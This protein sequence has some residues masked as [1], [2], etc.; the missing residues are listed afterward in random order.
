M[1][2]SKHEH[3]GLGLSVPRAIILVAYFA[4]VLPTLMLLNVGLVPDVLVLVLLGAAVVAGHPLLFVRDWGVFLLVVVLWQQ[5]GKVAT[6]A[7]YPLHVHELIDAD[8]WLTWP[9]L[10]G[11]LPQVWL[12]Q[13]LYHAGTWQWYDI[14]SWAVYGLHFPEPLL[15]GFVIWLRDPALFRR[16]SI[17]FLTL[18]SLAFAVY[19]LYPAVPPWMAASRHYPYRLIPPLTNI[20]NQFN[21]DVLTVGLGHSYHTVLHVD[22][23]LTAAMPSLHAAFPLLSALYLRKS[24][25]RWGLLMLGYGL[26]VWFSVVYMA[27]H[28]VIDVLAGLACAVIAY[29][30]VEAVARLWR[31]ARRTAP[32]PTFTPREAPGTVAAI[33]GSPN[34]PS[35][36]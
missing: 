25:G 14:M 36:D 4:A 27:E 10:H 29:V 34:S 33:S 18:A 24:I 17:A 11:T 35:F 31:A 30:L 3:R 5:T 1:L 2:G 32:Q 12:Q 20:F 13:H 9:W 21:H 8:K 16:Y 15:V 7:G 26:I 28:W 19:I 6:W 22:Y 23:N